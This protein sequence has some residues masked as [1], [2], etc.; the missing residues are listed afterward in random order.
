MRGKYYSSRD[1]Q[2]SVVIL[3]ILTPENGYVFKVAQMLL[4]HSVLERTE[5]RSRC[6]SVSFVAKRSRKDQIWKAVGL[7]ETLRTSVH[8]QIVN[9]GETDVGTSNAQVNNLG[10]FA[11]EEYS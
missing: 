7:T 1:T 3:N 10:M 2:L 4:N 8:F 6:I 5:G 11:H 9:A